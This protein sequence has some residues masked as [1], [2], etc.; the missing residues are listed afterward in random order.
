M[1]SEGESGAH[2]A[3][4]LIT[5]RMA[6]ERGRLQAISYMLFGALMFLLGVSAG[7]PSGVAKWLYVV[8]AVVVGIGLIVMGVLSLRARKRRVD[9]FEAQHGVGAGR[10][11]PVG[12]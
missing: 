1:A 2:T 10:Q 4:G 6:A 7:A 9:D 3:G 11:T 12:L 8:A 5:Q